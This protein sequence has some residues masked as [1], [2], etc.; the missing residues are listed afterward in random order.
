MRADSRS[1]SLGLHAVLNTCLKAKHD[2]QQRSHL[3][4]PL[5]LCLLHIRAAALFEMGWSDWK[6][7]AAILRW[8]RL[9][10]LARAC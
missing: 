2:G 6:S 1:A 3:D 8:S 5:T 4:L 10:A 9:P 7:M